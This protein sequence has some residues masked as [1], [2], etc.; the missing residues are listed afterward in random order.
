MD[1]AWKAWL[2]PAP[3]SGASRGNHRG[4]YRDRY[5]FGVDLNPEAHWFKRISNVSQPGS[6][7]PDK[8]HGRKGPEKGSLPDC[9]SRMACRTARLSARNASVADPPLS[10]LTVSIKEN[11]HIIQ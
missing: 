7:R 5:R 4:R 8:E 9:F 6:I 2:W 1:H 10:N 11:I 3:H